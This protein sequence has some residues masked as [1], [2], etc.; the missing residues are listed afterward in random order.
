MQ[1]NLFDSEPS[2]EYRELL[3]KLLVSQRVGIPID[4]VF[5]QESLGVELPQVYRAIC[6]TLGPCTLGAGLKWK[7]PNSSN[8]YFL[9]SYELLQQF[10]TATE[11]FRPFPLYPEPQ[12]YLIFASGD[13]LHLSFKVTDDSK[14]ERVCSQMVTVLDRDADRVEETGI[15][16]DEFL[17]RAITNN[18]PLTGE[19]SKRFHTYFFGNHSTLYTPA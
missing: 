19:I 9:L 18:R 13:R 4:W 3:L 12:G 11:G 5:V 8:T 1:P 10:A 7:S 2:V 6:D 16:L 15:P 17:F 14:H